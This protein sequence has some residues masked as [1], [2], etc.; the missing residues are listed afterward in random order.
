[1][2]RHAKTAREMKDHFQLEHQD[3]LDRE[4]VAIRPG[5]VIVT[6][7][8]VNHPNALRWALSRT[9]TEDRDVVV[10]SVR[11]MGAGGPEYL[12]AEEQS[13]SEHE[14]TV[15]TKAVSVAES[16]G[17]KVSLLV[18]PATEVFTALAQTASSLEVESVFSGSSSSLT[19]ED[20]AFHMGQAW[21]ALP[22]PKRQFNFC[23]VAPD[24][25]VKAFYIGPHAPQLSPEDVQLVH[26]LW[27]NM[28]RDQTM[29]DLHHSDIIT[30]ALTRLAGQY[31]RD[32]AEIL[33]NLRSYRIANIPAAPQLTTPTDNLQPSPRAIKQTRDQ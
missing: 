1:M 10:V 5:S 27:L 28:R 9:S 11:L 17:K 2:R 24:G 30:Y 29:Q 23:V 32:K 14:Q 21:E 12:N 33:R 26:R 19:A 13:F 20:Q 6:M 18:V 16:F 25:N 7:R 31:A 3:T 22:E 8:D 15:F 4:S